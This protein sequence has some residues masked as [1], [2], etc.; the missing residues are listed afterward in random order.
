[1]R[2]KENNISFLQYTGL[3]V[4]GMSFFMYTLGSIY[5]NEDAYSTLFYVAVLIAG[6]LLLKDRTALRQYKRYYIWQTAFILLI[7]LSVLYT[8]NPNPTPYVVQMF[9][10][11]LKVTTVAIICKNYEG[12][13][14]LL[15][16]IALVGVAV[17]FALYTRGLLNDVGRLGNEI[18][19]NANSFGLMTTVFY[20]G[21][22][23][24]IN[25]V[26]DKY[27]KYFFIFAVVLDIV[28]M[29]MTGGRKFLLFA[30]VFM[31]SSL[32][33]QG[34]IKPGRL[35]LVGFVT[36][37]IVVIMS[38][39]IMN[40]GFFYDA[41]GYRFDG[42]FS[43]QAEGVDDQEY[44]MQRGI[45]IFKERPFWGWGVEGYRYASKTGFYAHSNYVELLADYGIIGTLLYYSNLL[46]CA[47]VMWRK[48]MFQEEEFKFYFPLLIS[49]FVL[50]VLSISFNQT[51]YIPLFIMFITGYCYRLSRRKKLLNRVA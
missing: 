25:N 26:K 37:I 18:M 48:R 50:D 33:A 51:A 38:Y 49:I 32:L 39:I 45:E 7:S 14:K 27:L 13:K 17:F 21:A 24:S 3:G 8:V 34:T 36:G 5:E 40:V 10:I 35:L 42:M 46:W 19:G 31:F 43:G 4:L 2:P 11:L 15:L 16:C 28:L 23:S 9:K 44:L 12:V 6:A 41:I 22:F 29:A 1:M 47:L 30:M 20:I